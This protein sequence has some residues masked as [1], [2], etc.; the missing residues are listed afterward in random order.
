[1]GDQFESGLNGIATGLD[2]NMDGID[3][4]IAPGSYNDTDGVVSNPSTDLANTVGDT[5]EVAYREDLQV[6]DDIN[7]TQVDTPVSGNILTNDDPGDGDT[8]VLSLIHI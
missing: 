1:M 3:D 7:S 6:S 2:D 4:G 5:S 8:L